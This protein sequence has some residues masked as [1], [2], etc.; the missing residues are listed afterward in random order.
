M[1]TLKTRGLVI[2]NLDY[3]DTSVIVYILTP[4]GKLSVRALGAKSFKNKNHNFYEP[5]TYVSLEI[6]D[7]SFPT[8]IE[9]S[10]IDKF[11]DIKD[12]LKKYLDY[13]YLIE[14]LNH[15]PNDIPYERVLDYAINIIKLGRVSYSLNLILMLQIKF[16]SIFGIKPEMNKCL[17]CENKPMFLS[18]SKGYGLCEKHNEANSYLI[19]D[20][21]KLYSFDIKKDSLDELSE[22]NT[23]VILSFINDYY[24][25]H[26][27]FRLKSVNSL[28]I[29]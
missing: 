11:Q 23:S 3:K 17:Y 5:L 18:I 8:L 24:Q 28:I 16:L 25:Y 19:K 1:K 12:D 13:S 29:K 20:I 9:Y 10:I 7:S 14:Y 6:T 21:L 15:L 4:L 2:R 27:Y 26:A 22:I